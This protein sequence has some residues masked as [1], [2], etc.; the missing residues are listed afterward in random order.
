MMIS[1]RLECIRERNRVAARKYRQKQ[2]SRSS[3]LEEQG[4]RLV[5]ERDELM[6]TVK[7]LQ[8][9]VFLLKHR[10]VSQLCWNCGQA[11]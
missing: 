5:E 1:F 2:K 6:Q 11:S 4:E 7:R 8:N 3:K 9:E 10:Y